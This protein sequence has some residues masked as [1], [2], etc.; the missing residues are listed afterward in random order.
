MTALLD[1]ARL[2]YLYDG[3]LEGLL[4][5]VFVAF[6]RHKDPVNITVET[7]LQESLLLSP[8]PQLTSL[9]Q[10][11]RVRT[12]IIEKLGERS[13]ED[14]KLAFLSD[15][16]E[17]GGVI[18]RYLQY[19]FRKWN[20]R[21]GGRG[22]DA[23][24]GRGGGGAGGGGAGGG[25]AGGGGSGGGS[26][27]SRHPEQDKS[28]PKPVPPGFDLAHPAVDALQRLA[29]QVNTEAHYMLQFIR[30]AELKSGLYFAR[31]EP[32]ASV[33]PLIMDHFAERLNIQP[34]M[35]LD[36]RHG[37]AGVFNRERWWLVEADAT[38]VD[39]A[40]SAAQDDYQALWQSFYDTIAIEERRNPRCQR[41][42]MPKRFWGMMCEHIPPSLRSSKPATP[43]PSAAAKAL[44]AG[45]AA[46]HSSLPALP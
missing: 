17:K 25:G 31:I 46:T 23:A 10:A 28:R 6:E 2:V 1:D 26:D 32:K 13:Y 8:I 38:L 29:R 42:F 27:D 36:A 4:S 40:T 43:T 30:F 41:N 37:L 7:Q 34:F 9:A 16:P 11:E 44:A 12:G 21:R 15:Y 39:L 24:G 5:A 19:G 20:Q 14:I 45:K 22:R 33:V 35:I 3:T 18:L